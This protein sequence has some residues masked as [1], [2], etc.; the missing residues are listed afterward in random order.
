MHDALW[1]AH[2]EH[3][4]LGV[5]C[6]SLMGVVLAPGSGFGKLQQA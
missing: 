6:D 4:G 3:L 5:G 1:S 2:V